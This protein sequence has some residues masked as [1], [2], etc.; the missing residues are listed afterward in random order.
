MARDFTGP[1]P[2]NLVT[3]PFSRVA[4][5]P[6]RCRP[7]TCCGCSATTPATPSTWSWP[8]RR[9]RWSRPRSPRRSACT[10]TPCART[11]T[12][13]A[14]SACSRSP[15]TP[16]ARSAARSTATRWPPTPRRSASS[17]RRCRC[18][19]AWCCRWPGGSAP[20]RP[21]PSPSARPRA[22]ARAARYDDAPSA[23]E[24]LVA[25]LD[26]LG[27]DPIV[28]DAR[29]RRATPTPSPPS[30]R[31][32]TAR[33]PTSPATTPTSSARLHRG[34]V[35]G[36]VAQMGDAEVAEFCPLAHRTPCQVAV[37]SR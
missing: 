32:P 12:G 14:R 17:R 21:T 9:G 13:C 33:S 16:A 26:R 6:R 34:L 1:W 30:W 8:A 3:W 11:S 10:R 7:A 2:C 22:L 29:R 37:T 19:P 27:F 18:W 24:A 23:L 35:A 25:D 31:S 4:P 5:A 20:A 36:F 28:A 15:P